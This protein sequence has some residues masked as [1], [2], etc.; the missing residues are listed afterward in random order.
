M[1]ADLRSKVNSFNDAVNETINYIGDLVTEV[2]YG[3]EDEDYEDDDGH[4]KDER[5]TGAVQ[6]GAGASGRLKKRRPKARAGGAKAE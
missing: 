1:S 3:D 6:G 2:V 5:D 4:A